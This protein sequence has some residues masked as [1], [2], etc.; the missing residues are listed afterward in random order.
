MLGIMKARS[1]VSF[2]RYL[3]DVVILC[4]DDGGLHVEL[5]AL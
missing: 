3:E 4:S 2:Q 1:V 5:C